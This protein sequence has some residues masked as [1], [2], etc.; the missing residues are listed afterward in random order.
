MSKTYLADWN[1]VPVYLDFLPFGTRRTGQ[2]LD[3]GVPK[4]CV[5]HDTGNPNS[6]AQNNVDYYKRTYNISWDM[7]ASAHIFVDDIECIIC[8]PV[9]EKAWHVIYDT[10]TDNWCYGDDAN[11]IAFGLEACYFDD[12]ERSRKSLDNACRVMG[13][14]VG[15]WEIDYKNEMPGHQD[16]Q[17]DKQDPGNILAACGY[18]R[19]DMWRIDALVGKY[20]Q[21]GDT[22]KPKIEPKPAK[23]VKGQP[24]KVYKVQAGEGL[25]TISRKTKTSIPKIKELN[26]LTDKSVIHPNDILKLA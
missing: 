13:A 3:S 12:V 23:V 6:T 14:L 10:P 26:G 18:G 5:F 11:D 21:E 2:Q 8:I 19:G 15:S 9:T 20:E 16:I 25:W 1:G 17:D 24:K 22:P 4:F 7:V